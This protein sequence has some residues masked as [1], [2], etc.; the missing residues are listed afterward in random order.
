[1][2]HRIVVLGAG[3]AGTYSAGN[4][5]RHLHPDDIEITVVNAE[6][7]FVERLRLHQLAAGQDLK[8]RP[9]ADIFAGTGVR[10]RLARVEAVDPERKT[11][12]LDDGELA[13]DTLLF[14]LGSTV[15]GHGV[16]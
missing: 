7:D 3:Y 4:L 9:L 2:K 5:A 8:K 6:P 14:T 11:V 16:P 10:L 12:A 13:Y 1:M 15:A